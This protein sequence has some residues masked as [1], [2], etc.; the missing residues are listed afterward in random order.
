MKQNETPMFYLLN[1]K[2]HSDKIDSSNGSYPAAVKI[3]N[4]IVDENQLHFFREF[5]KTKSINKG[6][7][8]IQYEV[9]A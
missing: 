4:V 2:L 8:Y 9:I 5:F 3:K 7:D 1:L 6:L